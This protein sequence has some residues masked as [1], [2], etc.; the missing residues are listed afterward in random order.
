MNG[1]YVKKYDQNGILINPISK[2][3]FIAKNM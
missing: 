2:V 3:I 1:P